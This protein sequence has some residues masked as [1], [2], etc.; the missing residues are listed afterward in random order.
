MRIS[1][2]LALTVLTMAGYR[3]SL[4]AQVLELPA[5]AEG[6]SVLLGESIQVFAE[7][8]IPAYADPDPVRYLGKI[9]RFHLASGQ[10]G[11]SGG[12]R[13]PQKPSERSWAK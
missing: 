2:W 10:R 8:A 5:L 13:L 6:D 11:I 3:M 12:A 1:A 7:R 9:L 4:S